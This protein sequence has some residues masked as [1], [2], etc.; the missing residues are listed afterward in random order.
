MRLRN[1]DSRAVYRSDD[2][3]RPSMH[4]IA[5]EFA[6][7]HLDR[8]IVYESLLSMFESLDEDKALEEFFDGIPGICTSLT[9]VKA[10][11]IKP[12]K[13]RLSNVLIALLDRTLTS[14][15]VSEP[16]KLR[17]ITVCT[18]AIDVTSLLG[19]WWILRRV[20]LGNWQQ[21]L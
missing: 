1:R 4:K 9:N 3:S 15:L 10:E 12:N 11:F 6:V 5:E 13:E 18:K 17:R 21:F 19:P 14:N 8:K 16:V 2:I 7:N 20:L